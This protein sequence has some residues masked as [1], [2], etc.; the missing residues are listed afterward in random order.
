MLLFH[1]DAVRWAGRR[2]ELKALNS[3]LENHEN[4][5]CLALFLLPMKAVG[6]AEEVDC[7]RK[8]LNWGQ[9][10]T[11]L[12]CLA[13][14]AFESWI[15]RSV[16]CGR[17]QAGRTGPQASTRPD[18]A[19]FLPSRRKH[20]CAGSNRSKIPQLCAYSHIRHCG[21]TVPH[22]CQPR[23]RLGSER[24]FAKAVQQA[25][26]PF[27]HRQVPSLEVNRGLAPRSR[28]SHKGW[29]VRIPLA[30]L[31]TSA[32]AP[33]PLSHGQI[34]SPK[35]KRPRAEAPGRSSP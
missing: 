3:G 35:I 4:S 19:R 20:V 17:N 2:Q 29:P 21:K 9:Q 10:P 34:A 11:G 30:K 33:T 8:N 7:E 27:S 22:G 24:L 13:N 32:S 16:R 31:L 6:K 14:L 12:Q 23:L 28:H 15:Y 5:T 18:L 26:T 25:S 1:L